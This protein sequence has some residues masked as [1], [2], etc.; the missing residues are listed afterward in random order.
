MEKIH[1]TNHQRHQRSIQRIETAKLFTLWVCLY[2][3]CKQDFDG[4]S[5]RCRR[6]VFDSERVVGVGDDVKV[7]VSLFVADHIGI[8]LNAH[9]D[10][11]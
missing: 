1:R 2:L 7:H 6:H 10:I 9:T 4:E 11:T 5:S 3:V 8:T